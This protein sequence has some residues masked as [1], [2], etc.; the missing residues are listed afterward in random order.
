MGVWLV[1]ALLWLPADTA[2]A[3]RDRMVRDQIE[4]RGVRHPGVLRAMRATPRHLFIPPAARDLAYEDRPVPIGY[5]VTISQPYIVAWMSELLEP[6]KTHRV[7]EIGTGSGYQAAVLAQL[8]ERVYTIEIVPELAQ[9]A[10]ALLEKLGYRNITVREGDGYR[11]W[12]EE[13]PFDR[14]ILTAAPRE[15]PQTL[16]DQLAPGGRLVAPVGGSPFTQELL[17]IDK[18]P[19]G[20]IRR[21]SMGGVAFVPMVPK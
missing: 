16:I 14:V 21:R 19:D 9:S 11:G 15:V 8:V 3:A 1:L 5:S 6:A 4:D 17:V 18:R 20:S 12:P 7:L 10:R 13:A 2:T